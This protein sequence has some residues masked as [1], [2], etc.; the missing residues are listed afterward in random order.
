MEGDKVVVSV[1]ALDHDGDV[2]YCGEVSQKPQ[3]MLEEEYEWQMIQSAVEMNKMICKKLYPVGGEYAKKL[4]K[5]I[6][7]KCIEDMQTTL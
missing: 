3:F 5:H 7:D 6:Y 2:A 1:T 4:M